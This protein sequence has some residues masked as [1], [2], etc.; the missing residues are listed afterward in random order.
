MWAQ[1]RAQ[2]EGQ[3]DMVKRERLEHAMVQRQ[4]Q[5]NIGRASEQ[6]HLLQEEHNK[7]KQELAAKDASI[8]VLEARLAPGPEPQLDALPGVDVS[9]HSPL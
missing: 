8:A 2:W 3:N 9:S 4:L 5:E 1:E 6:L 7:V